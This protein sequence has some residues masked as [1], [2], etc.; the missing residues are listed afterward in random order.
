M[1]DQETIEYLQKENARLRGM[2]SRAGVAML[3]NVDLPDAEELERLY[4]MVT[5]SFPV[6]KFPETQKQEFYNAIHFLVFVY[7]VPT[8]S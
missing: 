2:L 3:P 6:L 5:S 4:R 1:T 7:R 8:E